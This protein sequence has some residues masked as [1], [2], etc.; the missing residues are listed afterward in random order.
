MVTQGFCPT[1]QVT[2]PLVTCP[3]AAPALP[4]R[5]LFR[6]PARNI[7]IDMSPLSLLFSSDQETSRQLAQALHEL[8]FEVEHCTE[9]FAAV[10]RLTSRSFEVIVADWDDGVEASFLLKTSRELTSNIAAFTVAIVNHAEAATAARMVG[11]DLV[12]NKPIT[13]DRVKYALLTCDEFLRCLRTWLP[14]FNVPSQTSSHNPGNASQDTYAYQ[15][16]SAANSNEPASSMPQSPMPASLSHRFGWNLSLWPYRGK[17]APARPRTQNGRRASLLAIACGVAAFSVGYGVSDGQRIEAGSVTKFY[18]QA[19]EKTQ[20]WLRISD[21]GK[22]LTHPEMAQ[23][24]SP[25]PLDPKTRTRTRIRITPV[26]D[27]SG[28]NDSAQ[29]P[30]EAQQL[31][32][33]TPLEPDPLLAV[34][35]H[36]PDSLR[37]PV[38]VASV[39][40]VAA[41]LGSTLLGTLEPVSISEDLSEKLLLQK[42]LP[43]YPEQAIKAGLQGPVVF[44]AWIGKDGT[45]RDLK[46]IRGYLV[47]G[48]AAYQAVKQWRYKPYSLNGQVVEAQTFVTVNFKL[49]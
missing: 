29:H 43:S 42:V 21:D 45:I 2:G 32:A 34:P 8:E 49:P 33:P 9:I 15:P 37:V 24:T 46:L 3:N 35:S 1:G 10:E 25:E 27:Y 44:Q 11:A 12:I 41:T 20:D 5:N 47:L 36:I 30:K 16:S 48:Q 22:S 23:S 17:A 18:E 31:K 4:L 38:Q 19:L 7:L 39:R 26:P 14:K 6:S 28:A 40:N 13:P